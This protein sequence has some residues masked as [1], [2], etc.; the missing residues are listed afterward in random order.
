M[1]DVGRW[2]LISITSKAVSVTP[3]LEPSFETHFDRGL[4][5]KFAY[6]IINPLSQYRYLNLDTQ[7]DNQKKDDHEHAESHHH[8]SHCHF[9]LA[10]K[11]PPAEAGLSTR[12]R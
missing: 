12:V 4:F 9:L 7:K 10:I 6:K 5:F 8:V 2:T 11:P 3:N 1:L